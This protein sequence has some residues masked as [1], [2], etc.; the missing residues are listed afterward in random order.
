M[1]QVDTFV[2]TQNHYKQSK[3]DLLDFFGYSPSP[4]ELYN[5][6]V[7]HRGHQWWHWRVGHDIFGKVFNK[8]SYFGRAEII[9]NIDGV[10]LMRVD[11]E[12]GSG[13]IDSAFWLL[14]EEKRVEHPDDEGVPQNG[15]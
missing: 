2:E 14:S 12:Y 13:N 10:V 6:V 1:S 5:D 15:F 9:G 8:Y 11:H 7:D 3:K 4:R